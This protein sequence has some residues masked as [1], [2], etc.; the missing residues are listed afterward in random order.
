MMSLEGCVRTPLC[1]HMPVSLARELNLKPQV[2][3]MC[4]ITGQFTNGSALVLLK[5]EH[6]S[7]QA[8][9]RQKP[10]APAFDTRPQHRSYLQ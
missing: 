9:T 4:G 10:K 7:E 1:K 8:L 6:F 2:S 3:A 5:V